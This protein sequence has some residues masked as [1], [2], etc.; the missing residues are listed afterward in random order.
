MSGL[1]AVSAI[2]FSAQLFSALKEIRNRVGS[3]S[4]TFKEITGRYESVRRGRV[5]ALRILGFL[6]SDVDSRRCWLAPW[7]CLA[8][9]DCALP[10]A[11]LVLV[12]IER[13]GI[14]VYSERPGNER[15]LFKARSF[16]HSFN[17]AVIT[18]SAS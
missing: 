16:S 17:A 7:T 2:A 4:G 3:G 9:A 18:R 14:Y 10:L 6:S 15:Y 11:W 1:A 13:K 8:D 5:W 12:T